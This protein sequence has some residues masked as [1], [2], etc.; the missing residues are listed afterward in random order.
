[1]LDKSLSEQIRE[2]SGD[3]RRDNTV[4]DDRWKSIQHPDQNEDFFGHE[5]L[6]PAQRLEI[7]P[8][9]QEQPKKRSGYIDQGGGDGGGAEDGVADT[10]PRR[11]ERE[12]CADGVQL[13]QLDEENR[14]GPG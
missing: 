8:D 5:S 1:M 11:S 4:I 9:Q 10:Y 12:E 14:T 3:I 6:S 7:Y 2:E 13:P